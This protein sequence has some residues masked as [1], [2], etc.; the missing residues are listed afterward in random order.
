MTL[1]EITTALKEWRGDDK[2]RHYTLIALDDD[3]GVSVEGLGSTFFL[4]GALALAMRTDPSIKGIVQW[5]MALKD[6]DKELQR[7]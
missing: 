3:E 7:E 4:G 6:T 5:A 2:A 1:D